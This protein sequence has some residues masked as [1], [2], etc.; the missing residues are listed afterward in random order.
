M[1]GRHFYRLLVLYYDVVQKVVVVL[2]MFERRE[3]AYAVYDYL[4]GV[5]RRG[6]INE[7]FVE[8]QKLQQ[9]GVFERAVQRLLYAARR[10]VYKL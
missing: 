5:E 8:V 7:R 9:L 3:L 1:Y 4:I 10:L 2:V 6:K